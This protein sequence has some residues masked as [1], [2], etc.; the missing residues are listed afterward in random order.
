MGYH[1][2]KIIECVF[3]DA[4]EFETHAACLQT[5]CKTANNGS[6]AGL[7]ILCLAVLPFHPAQYYFTCPA[8][9]HLH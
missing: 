7:R 2:K 6:G 5:A 8:F 1:M 4:A 9:G 3:Q